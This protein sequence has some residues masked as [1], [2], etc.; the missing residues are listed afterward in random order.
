MFSQKKRIV[1]VMSVVLS[2]CAFSA[3]RSAAQTP[4]PTPP[5]Y[6][7][8]RFEE[9]YGYLNDKTRRTETLDKLKYIS[10]GKDRF[11]VSLGGEVRL[12]YETYRNAAFGSGLQDNNGY[13]LGRL[14]LHS[15]WH[16]GNRLRAFAQVQS[17]VEANRNGGPR[18]TDRDT[19]D[20][21]QAFF[22]YI[23]YSD[24]KRSIA[25]RAGRQEIEFG[26]GHLVAASEGLNVRRSF[27][28]IRP[29]YKQGKWTANGLFAKLVAIKTGIFDDSVQS[30]QTFWGIGAVRDL[31]KASGGISFYYL[32]L[33]R[34]SAKFNQGN[35]R[36]IRH[37]FGNRIW[38]NIKKFDYN[39]EIIGQTGT[40]GTR[41]ILAWALA[42]ETGLN[43]VQ[44]PNSFRL[45]LRSNATSGDQD[46][47]DNKLQSFN[48]LFP[49]T[50]YSGTIALVGPTNVM[51]LSP[52]FRASI[53]QK[54]TLTADSAFYWR[55]SLND[56]L[57]G[58][59]VNLQRGGQQSRARFIGALPSVRTDYKF[60]RHWTFTAIYSH[61]VPGKFL[62]ESPPAENVEYLTSWI[63]FK[64]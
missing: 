47:L 56:G 25:I 23:L 20:L 32:G 19:L 16:L 10:L 59:N 15:D 53:G 62:K 28:A 45:A 54:L 18:A 21:H 17:G 42:T 33:N 40:F 4:T 8:L 60:D 49:A 2:I 11:Y 3:H 57:Y 38:G 31:P 7:S 9:D 61:F 12:R 63:S 55:Q 46:T 34:K 41:Q 52:S 1:F 48:P 22:D 36:E 64:F 44:R 26:S 13:F 30:Q 37:T 5:P 6:R 27:D 35:A 24:K 51:D 39:Y 14:L 43:F 29:I 50:A 58:I